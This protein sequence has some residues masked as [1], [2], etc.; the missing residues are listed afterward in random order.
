MN[1]YH[2]VDHII[3]KM[4]AP[5]W[6]PGDG[7]FGHQNLHSAVSLSYPPWTDRRSNQSVLKEINPESSL[8]PH[9]HWK[10]WCWRWSS[11]I[12]VT[13]REKP[14]YWKS[15]WCWERLRKEGEEGIRGWDGWTAS[16]MQWTWT[17]ANSGRRWGTGN[18]AVLQ[19]QGSQ[20]VGHNW[21]TEQHPAGGPDSAIPGV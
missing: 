16:L 12:S 15:P 1:S 7:N 20:R 11:S 2:P 21:M 5:I 14:T 6:G 18:P 9:T 4:L 13:W 10:N 8:N 3:L 17:W 19:F